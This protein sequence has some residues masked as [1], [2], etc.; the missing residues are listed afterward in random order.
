[1]TLN[2]VI[3]DDSKSDISS[4]EYFLQKYSIQQVD[5]D[6]STETFMSAEEFLSRLDKPHNYKIIFLD[7]E[8][9]GIDGI[10]LAEEIRKK[11]NDEILLIF[12]S[13]YPQYMQNSFQVQPFRFLTKPVSYSEF[14][15]VMNAAIRSIIKSAKNLSILPLADTETGKLII[16]L[17]DIVYIETITEKRRCIRITLSDGKKYEV[18]GII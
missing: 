11:E 2:T 12:V 1:M 16:R 9:T 6:F 18:R 17:D 8:M 5:T 15:P 4:L 7:I 10:T 14:E 13:S 3:C